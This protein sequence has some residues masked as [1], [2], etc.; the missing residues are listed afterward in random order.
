MGKKK[1]IQNLCVHTLGSY[2]IILIKEDIQLGKMHKNPSTSIASVID[3][4]NWITD[5][6]HV[7]F[8]SPPEFLWRIK[9][10][11][12]FFLQARVQFVQ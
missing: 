5:G 7:S 9:L 10:S 2:P 11:Y 4:N 12:I 3:Y 8:K 1:K 6:I